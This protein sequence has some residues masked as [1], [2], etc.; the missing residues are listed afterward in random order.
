MAHQSVQN[1]SN[2]LTAIMV[3]AI[4]FVIF[5]LAAVLIFQ[6]TTSAEIS[7][8]G[9]LVVNGI[10]VNEAYTPSDTGQHLAVFGNKAVNCTIIAAYNNT[11]AGTLIRSG[12]YTQS[13][14]CNLRNL[15]SEFIDVGW[16]VNYSYTWN[17]VSTYNTGTRAIQA[18]LISTIIN[19]FALMPTVGTILA[20]VIL[21][22]AIVILVLYVQRMRHNEGAT[23]GGSFEG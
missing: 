17:N 20:V 16:K 4:S 14:A 8:N 19:F 1:G 23:S 2:T 15:T 7:S 3:A 22:G 13:P 6:A 5:L 18:N 12:N 11:I 21:I 10:N 9:Y